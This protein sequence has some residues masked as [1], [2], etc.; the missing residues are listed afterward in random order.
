M[1]FTIVDGSGTRSVILTAPLPGSD[2][3]QFVLSPE[4][5]T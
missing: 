3:P 1:N 5:N 4:V 2:P